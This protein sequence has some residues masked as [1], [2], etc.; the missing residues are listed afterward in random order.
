MLCRKAVIERLDAEA[1]ARQKTALPARVPDR[2]GER[3]VQARQAGFAPFGIGAQED[4]GIAVGMETMAL[5][6]QFGAQ[7]RVVVEGAV[8]HQCEAGVGVVHRLRGTLREVDD[9]Q[10]AMPEC[11]RAVLPESFCIRPAPRQTG[12]HALDG[13]A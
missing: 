8:E 2:E 1:V 12:A 5:H 9:G 10:A 11:H 3:T 4:F 6:Q 7:F 13:F